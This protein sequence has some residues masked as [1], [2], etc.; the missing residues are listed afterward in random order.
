VKV[1]LFGATGMIGSGVLL[2]CLRDPD[3]TAVLSLVRGP[4]GVSHDKLTERVHDDFFDYEGVSAELSGF[5]ACFFCLGVSAF[6]MS[7]PAYHRITVDLTL[8]AA[9]ALL[10]ANPG[11][12]FCYV[13]G[14]S[15]DSTEQ[16]RQMWARVKGKVENR[17]LAMPMKAYMFR[18][19]YIQP[20]EG[21]RSKT[22]AYRIVYG[23]LGGLYPVFKRLFPRQVMTSRDLGLAM[24]QVA[25]SGNETHILEAA[26]INRI[27]DLARGRG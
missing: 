11:L 22:R 26:D 10:S 6:G 19:G 23:V 2:E 3:V 16:G 15:T 18:P 21:V 17:L 24:I 14:A 20:V 7:E 1:V 4:G 25:R 8:S 13:S 27:A 12:T 9:N 5:D